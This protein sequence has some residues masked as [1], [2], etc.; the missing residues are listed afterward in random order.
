MSDT[1][2]GLLRLLE[3]GNH[4]ANVQGK[5]FVLFSGLLLVAHE[6]GLES[7]EPELLNLNLADQTAVFKA[8]VKGSRG[9]FVGHGDAA[10]N[11][12][13]KMILPSFIRM[14]ETRA[15]C[16]ALRFYLGIGMCAKD[17]LPGS[18]HN[19]EAQEDAQPTV[20]GKQKSSAQRKPSAPPAST[21][22]KDLIMKLSLE[23]GMTPLEVDERLMRNVKFKCRLSELSL[24][25]AKHIITEMLGDGGGND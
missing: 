24:P 10:P 19:D 15:I 12:L 20:G 7:I 13:T 11:N 5:P 16:R 2:T 1:N 8:V 3:D 14:A 22:Q 6:N 17:E 9:T 23:R 4:I 25:Q 21:K 18:E